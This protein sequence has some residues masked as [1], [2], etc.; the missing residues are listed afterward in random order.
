[1]SEKCECRKTKK[2]LPKG[3][4]CKRCSENM[5]QIYTRTPMPKC[6]FNKL[7][8]PLCHGYSPV[9]LLHIFGTTFTKTTSG[10]L[11]LKR[12]DC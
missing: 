8:L 7:A 9:N 6:D 2:Q 12:L 5:L 3:V 4:L 10:R 1:M 11:L